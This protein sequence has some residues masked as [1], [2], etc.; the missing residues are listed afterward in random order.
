MCFIHID[1]QIFVK[2]W[3]RS[4]LDRNVAKIV[5][6]HCY[7]KVPGITLFPHILLR[8]HGTLDEN[9]AVRGSTIPIRNDL[10]CLPCL[11]LVKAYSN[12]GWY[13]SFRSLPQHSWHTIPSVTVSFF[14]TDLQIWTQWS[15]FPSFSLLIWI[16]IWVWIRLSTWW[17]TAHL[18]TKK[19][20][21]LVFFGVK[22]KTLQY[23]LAWL[24]Y[25]SP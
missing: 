22:K 7:N 5:L 18:V 17:W 4:T 3:R 8:L 19:I 15:A 23:Q 21:T 25:Q 20:Y 14:R 24:A 13:G 10:V 9:P 12:P 11:L 16:L 6:L 1:V 2:A